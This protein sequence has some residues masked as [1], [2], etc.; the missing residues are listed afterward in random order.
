MQAVQ[1]RV[2]KYLAR[3][4]NSHN[5]EFVFS[6]IAKR[7]RGYFP[8]L[9]LSFQ[10]DY[11]TILDYHSVLRESLFFLD[12]YSVFK[13]IILLFWIITLFCEKVCF[14]RK[15]C[16][17]RKFCAESSVVSRAVLSA[18]LENCEYILIQ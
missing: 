2:I 18:I 1:S 7:K 15:I 12:Y 5:S 10:G 3:S 9:L 6:S 8:G 13:R 17:A 16:F 4:V 14:P 11:S